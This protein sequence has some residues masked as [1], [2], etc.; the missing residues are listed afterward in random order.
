MRLSKLTFALAAFGLAAPSARAQVVVAGADAGSFVNLAAP[1]NSGRATTEFWDNISA[2]ETGANTSCNIGFFATG[3]LSAGCMN[4]TAGSSGNQGGFVSYW[5]DNGPGGTSAGQ[6]PSSFLFGGGSWD[7]TLIG[8]FSGQRS[9]VGWFTVSGSI[10]SFNPITLWGNKVLN[11]KVSIY[12][13]SSNWGLYIRNDFNPNAGGC[14]APNY[15]CSDATGGYSGVPFQQFALFSQRSPGNLPLY[16]VGAED[17]AL[18]LFGQG[19]G[20]AFYRDSD[21]N[22]YILSVQAVPEPMTMGL[23]AMGLVGLAGA[24]FVRNRRKQKS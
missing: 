14:A 19:T 1:N 18:E 10:Y 6:D 2:D 16:L 24:G 5:G 4:E 21:Y 7:I 11:T 3:T 12:T 9:E 23:L 17:N 22:D 13:G 8:A 20:P 15:N